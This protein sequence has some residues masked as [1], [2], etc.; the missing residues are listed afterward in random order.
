MFTG[1]TLNIIFDL[2]ID[3]CGDYLKTMHKRNIFFHQG[4][5]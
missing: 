2:D 4:T 1:S 3:I 5:D